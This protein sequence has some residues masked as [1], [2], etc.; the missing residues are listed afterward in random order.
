MRARKALMPARFSALA[1]T[2]FLVGCL[3]S[4]SNSG[5]ERAVEESYS[6]TAKDRGV[7]YRV[8]FSVNGRAQ[9]IVAGQQAV[10]RS[11]SDGRAQLRIENHSPLLRC[12]FDPFGS[13]ALVLEPGHAKDLAIDC[14]YVEFVLSLKHDI[15]T[16]ES[17][18]R[19]IVS[20]FSVEGSKFLDDGQGGLP[21]AA[22]GESL[23]FRV[24]DAEWDTYTW[25]DGPELSWK[26]TAW[27]TQG[28]KATT[29]S[30]GQIFAL[31]VDESGRGTIKTAWR[32]DESLAL[33]S[34]LPDLA[35]GYSYGAL[36]LVG[37]QLIAFSKNSGSGEHQLYA[38]DKGSPEAWRGP[39]AVGESFYGSSRTHSTGLINAEIAEVS[40]TGKLQWFSPQDDSYGEWQVPVQGVEELDLWLSKSGHVHVGAKYRN[41]EESA[42]AAIYRFDRGRWVE[43]RDFCDDHTNVTVFYWR[44]WGDTLHA[45]MVADDG[46]VIPK[47]ASL[48]VIHD[49]TEP[50]E[51]VAVVPGDTYQGGFLE[52]LPIEGGGY[53]YTTERLDDGCPTA[54]WSCSYTGRLYRF[55]HGSESTP[56]KLFEGGWEYG[57]FSSWYPLL[58]GPWPVGGQILFASADDDADVAL[59]RSDGSV[60]GTYKVLDLTQD[61]EVVLQISSMNAVF[62]RE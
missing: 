28:A 24:L 30:G 32:P 14:D 51:E 59:W 34:T 21:V 43:L 25:T 41:A 26:P 54:P 58:S 16:G 18:V 47:E 40:G 12:G 57:L 36:S 42:C 53:F 22:F 15:S 5:S 35:D 2:V 38:V 19:E 46:A 62:L 37:D 61:S 10:V 1:L 20:D 13:K 48:I 60:P 29:L 50:P 8:E 11:A 6:L 9:T 44:M 17:V 52:S 27:D 7:D 56:T 23:I 3:D 49:M 55:E 31:F 39:F 33:F 45:S 4:G